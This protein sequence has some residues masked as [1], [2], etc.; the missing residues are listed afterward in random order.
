MPTRPLVSLR[1]SVT[2]VGT[3]FAAQNHGKAKIQ[4]LESRIGRD[5]YVARLQIAMDDTMFMRRRQTPSASCEPRWII[6][7]SESGPDA[8]IASRDRP[9]ISSSTRKSVPSCVSKS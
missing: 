4:D 1:L 7:F 8:S 6:S 9:S 3:D 2:A 5:A